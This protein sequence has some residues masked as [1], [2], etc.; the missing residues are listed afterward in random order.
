MAYCWRLRYK[1]NENPQVF[2]WNRC[3]EWRRTRC[4]SSFFF[5]LKYIFL[6]FFSSAGHLSWRQ[7]FM[8]QRM[9]VVSN[10][11]N[12]IALDTDL[13]V[14]ACM[15]RLRA[16]LYGCICV[17]IHIHIYIYMCVCVCVCLSTL[18]VIRSSWHKKNIICRFDFA[19]AFQVFEG[20]E[21]RGWNGGYPDQVS[22]QN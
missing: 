17:Y 11:S 19:L 16:C 8:V 7:I 3:V 1:A 5:F 2:A 21:T 14:S 9:S 4:F 13:C 12:S 22:S 15:V 6:F 10:T 18:H 20:Q